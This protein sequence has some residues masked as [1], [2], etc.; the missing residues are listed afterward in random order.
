MIDRLDVTKSFGAYYLLHWDKYDNIFDAAIA[1]YG[2]EVP[3]DHPYP[4]SYICDQLQK[5]TGI[6]RWTW[7][8]LETADIELREAIGEPLGPQ[9]VAS[10]LCYKGF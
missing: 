10:Y 3:N 7:G 4:A 5:L 1:Y 2:I 9:I 8:D 6:S